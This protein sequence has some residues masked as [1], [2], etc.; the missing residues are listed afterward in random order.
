MDNIRFVSIGIITLGVCICVCT[1]FWG[2]WFLSNNIIRPIRANLIVQPSTIKDAGNGVF[3]TKDILEG[4]IVEICPILTEDKTK[5][6]DSIFFDYV[7]NGSCVD[8]KDTTCVFPLGY[9]TLY[10]HSDDNN[11]AHNIANNM[12]IIKA[13][14]FIPANSELFITYGDKWWET[15]AHKEKRA[16]N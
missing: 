4:E 11:C 5:F 6:K 3:T 2:I 10:N 14:R 12:M 1:Y 7:F 16:N 8:G 9:G 13:K 15:R